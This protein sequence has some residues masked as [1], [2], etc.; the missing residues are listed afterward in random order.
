MH[1][2][3]CQTPLPEMLLH[4]QATRQSLCVKLFLLIWNNSA[5]CGVHMLKLNH[6]AWDAQN[7]PADL[8]RMH[9][10]PVC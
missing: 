7:E 6:H 9:L 5:F 2:T 10:V 4:G 8:H 1:V 3:V